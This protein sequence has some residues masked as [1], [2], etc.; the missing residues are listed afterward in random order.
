MTTLA[1]IHQG[2]GSRPQLHS[3]PTIAEYGGATGVAAS[4]WAEA[5][6]TAIRAP[7]NRTNM[8]YMI[9]WMLAEG[10]GGQNNPLNTKNE[11]AGYTGGV[12]NTGNPAVANYST[13]AD[14]V[15]NI[16]QTLVNG[17]YPAIVSSL[18]AG[19]GMPYEGNIPAEIDLWGTGA[20]LFYSRA[21]A[22]AFAGR[23]LHV[24]GNGPNGGIVRPGGPPPPPTSSLDQATAAY[25]SYEQAADASYPQYASLTSKLS[26]WFQILSGNFS[27]FWGLEHNPV[28]DAV[29]G[30]EHDV[31]GLATFGAKMVQFLGGIPFMFLRGVEIMFG[32]VMLGFGIYLTASHTHGLLKDAI[33]ASPIGEY[34]RIAR[35]TREGGREGRAEHARLSSRRSERDRLAGTREARAAQIT[36]AARRGNR[37]AQEK[38]AERGAHR[39]T[40]HRLSAADRAKASERKTTEAERKAATKKRME[41]GSKRHAATRKAK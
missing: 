14:G 19:M 39:A 40:M 4:L 22:R 41:A 24:L 10:G 5:I 36:S 34:K 12:P 28:T 32:S 29:S 3:L 23:P 27:Q 21:P 7:T 16:A 30:A 31:S 1:R 9:G 13:P 33:Q 35:A 6:L 8:G 38:H 25:A 11:G 15:Y 17:Y 26:F 2:H 20:Q 18:R 37:T